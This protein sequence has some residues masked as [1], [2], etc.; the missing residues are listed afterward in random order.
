MSHNTYV[1][2]LNSLHNLGAGGANALA[3]SQALNEYFAELYEP[4]PIVMS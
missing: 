2:Y 3:E 1:S 4:F